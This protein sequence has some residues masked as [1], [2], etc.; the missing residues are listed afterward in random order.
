MRRRIIHIFNEHLYFFQQST[1]LNPT[2]KGTW[3]GFVFRIAL[4]I[5]LVTV[6][7]LQ[8]ITIICLSSAIDCVKFIF[9]KLIVSRTLIFFSP[10]LPICYLPYGQL[11][12]IFALVVLSNIIVSQQEHAF[13]CLG[14]NYPNSIKF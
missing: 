7:A 12:L 14:L 11:K 10:N 5:Q 2:H 9:I 13:S 6:Q 1:K 4:K 3:W 8:F